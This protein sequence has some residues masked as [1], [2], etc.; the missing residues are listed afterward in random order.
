MNTKTKKTL[1]IGT[2]ILL[3]VINISALSTIYY[4][5]KIRSKK[6]AEI[7]NVQKDARVRGMRRYIQE[8]LNFSEEQYKQFREIHTEYMTSSQEIASELNKKRSEMMNE[9]AKLNPSSKKLDQIAKDIG[10]MHYELKKLTIKHF[11][12]LKNICNDDQQEALQKMFMHMLNGRD[13]DRMDRQPREKNRN[14][15]R[16]SRE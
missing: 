15:H 16:K 10:E 4:H 7:S 14:K 8:E 1:L 11:I 5:K 9:V 13:H 12:E 3:L 2:I 6:S